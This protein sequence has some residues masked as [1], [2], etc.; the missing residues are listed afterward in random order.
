[1]NNWIKI[2][3]FTL[4][5]NLRGSKFIA[6]TALV[7]IAIL[8]GTLLSNMLISGAFNKDS[9]V[10]N[11][12]AVYVVNET[13]LSLD[14]D[15]FTEKNQKNYP[16]L[17]I[18]EVSGKTAEEAASDSGLLGEKEAYSI[19]LEVTECE[20]GCVLTAFIP[21]N[22][23]ITG[24][25][26]YKFARR[27]SETV[28]NAKI[29]NTGVSEDKLNMAISDI[30]ITEI[31]AEASD[32]AEDDS[33]LTGFA[34][35]F[36]MMFL[37]FLL[38]FYGQSIGS[39]ISSEKTSK[40]MEYMLTL[41][42]PTAIVF[43][44]V[45]AVF[46]EAV[47]QI[48]V[49][50]VC[51][52]CGIK[53]SNIFITELTGG[54]GKDII[55]LFAELLPEG[56]LSA[57]FAVLFVLSV[58][59]LL[60]AFLFYSF[61]SALFASFAATVEELTQTNAMSMMVMVFGFI[62]TMYIPLFTDNSPLGMAIIRIIPF[63]AAFTLP[64]QII[65]GKL[66]IVEFILYTALLLVFTVL[67]AIL[68]GRVYKNRL[69]KK[70]TKGIFDEILFA[71]TG[72]VSAKMKSKDLEETEASGKELDVTVYENHDSAKK[73]YTIVGFG[74]LALILGANA[75]GGG[76]MAGV[77]ANFMA[78]SKNISL[79]E[80]YED[81]N[82]LS[83]ANIISMYLLACPAC[84]LVMQL[85]NDS[86]TK[87]KGHISLNQYLRSIFMMFP[88]AFGLNYL[89]TLLASGLSGGEAE[90]SLN[91]LLGG[92]NIPAMV[93]V[94]VLAPIFEEL[95]FRKLI[96]DRT[97]RYGE[98]MSILFSSLAF[99]LFHCNL[100]QIFY[101]F[102]L[103]LILGYVYVRTGN[104][105]L[106]IIMHM[107]VNAS[108]SVLAPLAPQ[109][110]EYFFYAMI[111]LGIVSIIYTLI[112]RD[113]KFEKAHYQVPSKELSG[114]AFVNVGSILFTAVCIVMMIYG[115]FISTLT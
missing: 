108:S 74:L 90:N 59:A 22:S 82:F 47:F 36:I 68:T 18:S 2:L 38:L 110:Y 43:G 70:G 73:T 3:K 109:V 42:G 41:T 9:Q 32:E 21:E 8:I 40:L 51:G 60:V 45:T 7:G 104:V 25:E 64:G 100:Y 30:H 94:A 83:T 6:S 58:I 44:K 103:G 24:N 67:M 107:C 62:A 26:S 23:T 16:E 95:V 114:I 12:K 85:A 17:Y 66:S 88:L 65:C 115:L 55:A 49:W 31:K 81:V 11:L 34:P 105:I 4:K 63:T 50:I 1:M 61:V 13:E 53:V 52:F 91:Q 86:K 10:Q 57:N 80:V 20:E 79:N 99:G 27:F 96:I 29:K 37:Y 46:C 97:I 5:Q 28:K 102:V 101:A 56:G 33:L 72:K 87:I 93:M 15:S 75:I 89:S 48:V 54:S 77:I 14:T 78:A 69:F 19:V 84:A 111:G 71:I 112:K 92:D 76:L 35:L 106:T 39:I 113:V 98:L